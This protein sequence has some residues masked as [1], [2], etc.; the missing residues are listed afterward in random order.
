MR[1]NLIILRILSLVSFFFLVSCGIST[2]VDESE[3]T[4]ASERG[5]DSDKPQR[6]NEESPKRDANN[7]PLPENSCPPDQKWVLDKGCVPLWDLLTSVRKKINDPTYAPTQNFSGLKKNALK[8]LIQDLAL[9]DNAV[10]QKS[11][12]EMLNGRQG[13]FGIRQKLGLAKLNLSGSGLEG[14]KHARFLTG[15]KLT[16][17]ENLTFMQSMKDRC[18]D[19]ASSPDFDACIGDASLV[20]EKIEKLDLSLP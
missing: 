19:D 16:V 6:K 8:Q 18:L 3:Q 9:H 12:E 4:E 14:R 5:S 10:F 7:K 17:L 11:A 2:V 13:K 1:Q 15:F 20:L